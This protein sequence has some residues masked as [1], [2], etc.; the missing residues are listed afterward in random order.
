MLSDIDYVVTGQ[1]CHIF[2][3]DRYLTTLVLTGLVER[4]PLEDLVINKL[5]TEAEQLRQKL[6]DIEAR[7]R[8]IVGPSTA[9]A[10]RDALAE[11]SHARMEAKVA[12]AE[13]ERVRELVR[14]V[15]LRCAEPVVE[16]DGCNS[17]LTSPICLS[18]IPCVI[19]PRA[20]GNLRTMAGL[21]RSP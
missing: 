1:L 15:L 7:T 3:A 4:P 16:R 20:E 2:W 9:D 19:H 13:L 5:K 14:T 10:L 21:R 11:L 8:E 12:R 17:D 6:E 18:R